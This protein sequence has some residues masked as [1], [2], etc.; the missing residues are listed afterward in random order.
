MSIDEHLKTLRREYSGESLDESGVNADPFRQ[1]EKWFEDAVK[2]EISDP[3]AMVVATVSKTGKPSARVVLLRG[4]EQ[5]GFVFY[6]NY[7]SHKG[8]DLLGTPD[9]AAVFYWNQLDRQVRIEGTVEKVSGRESDDYFH[10]RP[11][12]SQIAAWASDQS[13]VIPGRA[14]LDRRYEEFEK[15]FAGK[16]VP[17]PEN[18]GGLR[19]IPATYE[20][21]QGRPNRLHDR[22]FYETGKTGKW[23]I[24]RLAP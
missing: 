10:S 20:F 7:R 21:W 19:I 4:F 17:R 8:I 6:T 14:D 22:I 12:E 2:A 16:T 3:H 5:N 15:E 9:V 24:K 23:E 1:F 18:W 11:R 13:K